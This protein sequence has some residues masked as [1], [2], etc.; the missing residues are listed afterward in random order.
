MILAA[1][2]ALGGCAE[3]PRFVNPDVS[4]DQWQL[5]RS[6]CRQKADDLAARHLDD[7]LSS[8]QIT[9]ATSGLSKQ[10]AVEDAKD[11]R[12]RYYQGCLSAR[13]YRDANE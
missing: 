4:Q 3:P 6:A 7:E 12:Q 9:G 10:M 1:G 11:M 2:L 8:N 13:G 5:D